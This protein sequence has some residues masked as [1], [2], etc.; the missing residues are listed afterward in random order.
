MVDKSRHDSTLDLVHSVYISPW[1][2]GGISPASNPNTTT[3]TETEYTNA[4]TTDSVSGR[5][6]VKFI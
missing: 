3:K 2:N 1:F 5:V 4:C 6:K